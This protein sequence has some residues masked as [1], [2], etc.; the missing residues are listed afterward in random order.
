MKPAGFQK[1]A[2]YLR[3]QN[4]FILT[5]FNGLDPD[6]D[7]SANLGVMPLSKNFVFGIQFSL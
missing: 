1:C 2:I 3:A 5:K 7:E 6:Y 4:L